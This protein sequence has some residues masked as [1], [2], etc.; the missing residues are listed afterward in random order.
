MNKKIKNSFL[1]FSVAFIVLFVI[2]VNMLIFSFFRKNFIS[3]TLAIVSI[4]FSCLGIFSGIGIISS[5][6]PD[7]KVDKVSAE[8]IKESFKKIKCNSLILTLFIVSA[9]LFTVFLIIFTPV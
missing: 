4:T 3:G 2:L 5:H 8:N 9:T 1:I 7:Y 6:I